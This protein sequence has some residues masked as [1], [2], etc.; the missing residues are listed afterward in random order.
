MVFDSNY[1]RVVKI[2]NKHLV[3]AKNY[4]KSIDSNT[5]HLFGQ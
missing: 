3:M 5:N 4:L 2:E 1:Y